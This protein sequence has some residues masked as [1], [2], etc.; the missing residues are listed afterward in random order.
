M[1]ESTTQD[2][3]RHFH[4]GNFNFKDSPQSER[5]AQV[6]NDRMRQ[7]IEAVLKGLKSQILC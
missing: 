4:N 2:W 3:F 6:N 1:S 5:P 7:L